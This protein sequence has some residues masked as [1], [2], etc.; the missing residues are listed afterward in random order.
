MIVKKAT[1][2]FV[3]EKTKSKRKNSGLKFIGVAQYTITLDD[4]W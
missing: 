4:R 1:G 3:F 2:A